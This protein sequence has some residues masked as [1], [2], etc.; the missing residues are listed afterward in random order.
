[1]I[2]T[3]TLNPAIDYRIYSDQV[4]LGKLN[5]FQDGTLRAGGKGINVSIVLSKFHIDSICTGFLGGF[6]GAFIQSELEQYDHIKHR[7]IDVKAHTR[8]NVKIMNQHVETE[9]NH[10]GPLISENEK[11]KLIHLID[12]MDSDDILICGGSTANGHPDLYQ[13][14]AFHCQTKKITLIMDTPGTYLSQFIAYRPFL[15]KPNIHE[16]EDYFKTP[17]DTIPMMI[18]YGKEL[19]RQ[20][21]ENVL[22]SIGEQGSLFIS[23]DHVYR[24]QLIKGQVKSTVGA[25]DSMVAGFVAGLLK[26][27]DL[28][29]AYQYA[30]A[31]ATASIFGDELGDQQ[32]FSKI[33]DSI[34]IEAINHD[35]KEEDN[36]DE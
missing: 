36:I 18:N 17:I 1:M 16:L 3:C 27:Q 15:I 13:E 26:T 29:K 25:G 6:T 32:V 10:E 22:L 4:V 35:F 8:I 24:A 31:S 23:K 21:A 7:F 2:Y 12:Q 20:G 9:F 30:V 11:Q 14:I 19:I 5:R 28:Q 34:V 33:I